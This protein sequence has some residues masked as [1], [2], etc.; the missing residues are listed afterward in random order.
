MAMTDEQYFQSLPDFEDF[1]QYL[2]GGSDDIVIPPFVPDFSNVL[3]VD[4]IPKVG[5]EKLPKLMGVILK[6]Y[7][8]IHDKLV[9]SDVVMPADESTKMTLGFCFITFQD[10]T[11]A[12]KAMEVTQGFAIDKKHTFTV[13]LYSDLDKYG[14]LID[15]YVN[16]DYPAFK[17]RPDPTSWLTDPA[18]RD[19]FAIRHS[20]ETVINWANTN[21]GDKPSLVYDGESQKQ[22]GLSW[23]ESYVQWSPQGT[24]LA[25]FHARGVKLWGGSSFEDQGKFGHSG[26][27]ELN[28]SG[29]EKYLTT[30][31]FPD[32]ND[33]GLETHETIIVWDI[34]SQT[35]L[36]AFEWKNPLLPGF[37]VQATTF[38]RT[39]KMIKEGKDEEM[40]VIRG[41][42][43]SYNE[44]EY[45]FTIE[46]G[47]SKLYDNVRTENIQQL[48]DPNRLKWSPDGKYIAKLD[49]H[50]SSGS[51]II[52]IYELPGMKLLDKKSLVAAGALDFTWSPKNN[53]IAYW[54]PAVGNLPAGIKIVGIPDR[55]DISSRKL[56]QVQEG[57]MFWQD[58]GDYLCVTMV[59]LVGKKRS[60]II[61]F[62]RVS[63]PDCPVEQLELSETIR[64]VSWEPSGDRIA[65]VTGEQ[66]TFN[67]SFYSMSG[68]AK[69]VSSTGISAAL[70]RQI[71]GMAPEPK[72]KQEK[73]I[74]KKEL[75]LLFTLN[76]LQATDVVW[77]PAGGI[78]ALA[79]Y[80]SD[81]CMF[82]LHDV[83]NNQS[84]ASR[85][86]D[87]GNR[88]VWDPSGRILVSCT[89]TDIKNANMRGHPSDG[90]IMYTFQGQVLNSVNCEKLFQFSWRPRPRDLLSKDMKKKITKN[91]KK[92][93]KEFDKEDRTKR[94]ELN[95]ENLSR[96]RNLASDFLTR[97]RYNE[98]LAI[99]WK[100][101]R[102]QARDG[103][104]SEDDSNYIFSKVQE[105]AVMKTTETIMSSQ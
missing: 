8:K 71:P 97:I 20:N 83:D 75:T 42:V 79:F 102:V 61:M 46:E 94:Q 27:Q 86:H 105:E 64:S 14:S 85:R 93:E 45:C 21:A 39:E 10:S 58:Q 56:Y 36:R 24:Y 69:D 100:T 25:T 101:Q 78:A 68:I 40:L 89:I 77:S 99:A 41:R 35:K 103:Y 29:C 57:R 55:S 53:M 37:Q 73:K 18:C 17:A 87:R 48:Q 65:I 47:G 23:C 4:G 19:Q 62:F 95:A 7:M 80:P 16:K 84:L 26:V 3:I 5:P 11:Q 32:P 30:Y 54:A 90:Y 70:E 6:I 15:T 96:R 44:N 88:L 38:F 31:S 51:D 22:G 63:E 91:L 82:D 60:N 34:L 52:S 43:K 66:R 1:A 49:I 67:I 33:P 81:T 13:S 59:K 28:F 92:Y 72:K 9:E 74:E 76:G 2:E 104:D 98:N 50:Q 12:E